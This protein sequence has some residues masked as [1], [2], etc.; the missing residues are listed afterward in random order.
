MEAK[1]LMIGD[2]VRILL[3]KDTLKEYNTQVKQITYDDILDSYY[4]ED[5][6]NY[7]TLK[8]VEPIP[9]TP[10]ILEIN[11][12]IKKSYTSLFEHYDEHIPFALEIDKRKL[13]LV[14]DDT[15]VISCMYVH[16]LQHALR[17]C[18]LCE[19]AHYFIVK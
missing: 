4:V 18:G 16:E 15:I 17:L 14:L 3:V 19:R 11:G 2:W 1:E 5:E 12:W 10:E 7:V 6:D 8:Y 9:L 13:Y